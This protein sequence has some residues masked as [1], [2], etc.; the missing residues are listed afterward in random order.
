MGYANAKHI[1][2][3]LPHTVCMVHINLNMH[4]CVLDTAIHCVFLHRV[5]S[6][7]KLVQCTE[8][9]FDGIF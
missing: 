7:K 3:I 8:F 1:S 9:L 6:C 4:I 2:V 5:T